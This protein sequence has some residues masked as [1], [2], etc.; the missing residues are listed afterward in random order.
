MKSTSE[1]DCEELLV[2]KLQEQSDYFQQNFK[3]LNETYEE[4]LDAKLL[5]KSDYFEDL[6]ELNE[7]YLDTKSVWSAM[8]MG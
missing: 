3:E 2:A 1:G 6:K 7:T 8:T 4:S 5:E